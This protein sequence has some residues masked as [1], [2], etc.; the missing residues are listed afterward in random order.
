MQQTELNL[1]LRCDQHCLTHALF[2]SAAVFGTHIGLKIKFLLKSV[3]ESC[4]H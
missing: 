2:M 3:R 4:T 1:N